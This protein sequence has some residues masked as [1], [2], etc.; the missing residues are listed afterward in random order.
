MEAIRPES[1]P[2]RGLPAN[3]RQAVRA[4][5]SDQ[6]LPHPAAIAVRA[7]CQAEEEAW[8][9]QSG[10]PWPGLASCLDDNRAL[11]SI[12]SYCWLHRDQIRLSYAAPWTMKLV[13]PR[14]RCLP[15]G[16]QFHHGTMGREI[17]PLVHYWSPQDLFNN[18]LALEPLEPLRQDFPLEEFIAYVRA[19]VAAAADRRLQVAA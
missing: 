14:T 19:A 16:V 6:W 5:A 11:M 3:V 13:C 8:S 2:L 18:G 10:D 1:G 17:W 15:E 7:C 9:R 4:F 12:Q